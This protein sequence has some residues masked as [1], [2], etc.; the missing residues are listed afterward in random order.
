M[1]VDDWIQRLA[2]SFGKLAEAQEPYLKE[3]YKYHPR[4]HVLSEDGSIEPRAVA[5][6]DLRDLYDMACHSNILGEWRYFA[7]LG[8]VLDPARNIVRSHPTLVGVMN[9]IVGQDEFWMEIL[10]NGHSTSSGD[11]VAELIARAAKLAGDRFRTAA[12]G[13][14]ELLD[15]AIDK[16]MESSAPE[17]LGVGWVS[18]TTW[19]CSAACP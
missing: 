15:S 9:P 16:R 13:L 4:V 8:A 6:D 1:T 2:V 12:A 3:Y 17:G 5:L 7:P 18:D 11:L 14:N 19:C 10:N